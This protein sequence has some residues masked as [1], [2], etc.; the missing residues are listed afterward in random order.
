MPASSYV[1]SLT[2]LD[3]RSAGFDFVRKE[4]GDFRGIREEEE[5]YAASGAFDMVL[6]PFFSPTV[7]SFDRLCSF[8]DSKYQVCR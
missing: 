3:P 7:F 4:V 5:D 2:C 8:S 6:I 1:F